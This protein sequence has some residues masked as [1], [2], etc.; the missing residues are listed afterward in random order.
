MV[1]V[2]ISLLYSYKEANKEAHAI[3]ALEIGKTYT[4]S[5]TKP[6]DGFASAESIEFTIQD[7]DEVQKVTMYDDT[8]KLEFSK[9]TI[10]RTLIS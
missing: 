8:T 10:T 7:T 4:L 6:A 1:D 9:T 2:V 3:K 5:E